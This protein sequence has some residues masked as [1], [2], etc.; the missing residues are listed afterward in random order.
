MKTA[1]HMGGFVSVAAML[2]LALAVSCTQVDFV[3]DPVDTFEGSE[4]LEKIR[5]S[6]VGFDI[7]LPEDLAESNDPLYVTVAMNRIQNAGAHYV[8]DLDRNGELVNAPVDSSGRDP[9]QIHN[10]YYSVAAF[11]ASEQEEYAIVDIEAFKD[12]L[13]Y[14]MKELYVT[15]PELTKDEKINLGYIDFNPI[16]PYVRNAGPSWYG[17]PTAES[18]A[19]ITSDSETSNIIRIEPMMLTR[20][21][22]FSVKIQI[23]E[24]VTVSRC[25]GT[26]SGVPQKVHLMTGVVSDS[27]TGKIGFEMDRI[28]DTEYFGYVNAF[29]LFGSDNPDLIVGPGIL[30]ITVYASAESNGRTRKRIFNA[31]LNLKKEIEDLFVMRL[32]KDMTGYIFN[33]ADRP[34]YSIAAD[35]GHL[36]TK[37]MVITGITS[38]YEQWQVHDD[39]SDKDVNPGLNPEI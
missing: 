19:L 21:F 35:R 25:V 34:V 5:M 23:E 32:A 39:D 33:E 28:S 36:I 13:A 11:V 1:V 6:K 16:Y 24:G 9:L 10:G 4:D 29:G 27:H 38:G 37:D 14:S 2:L 30:S 22:E 7:D 20:R 3:G 8:Y 15:M 17:R 31:S 18:L 12:S 26:I